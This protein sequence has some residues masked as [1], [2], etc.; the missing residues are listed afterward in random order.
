MTAPIFVSDKESIK[1]SRSSS[2]LAERILCQGDSNV[3]FGIDIAAIVDKLNSDYFDEHVKLL[4]LRRSVDFRIEPVLIEYGEDLV[5]FTVARQRL[6]EVIYQ[7]VPYKHI[8]SY[9]PLDLCAVVPADLPMHSL[10]SLQ[11]FT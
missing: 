7:I 6:T 4:K 2:V 5:T 11:T 3:R 9:L 10:N 1:R 8:H